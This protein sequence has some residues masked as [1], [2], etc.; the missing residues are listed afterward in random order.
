M[1]KKM[2]TLFR[3]AGNSKVDDEYEKTSTLS[4]NARRYLELVRLSLELEKQKEKMYLALNEQEK[5]E[6]QNVLS[7]ITEPTIP[8]YLTVR[9]VALLLD[10]TPQMVRRYC[11]EGKIDAYQRLEGSG[12]WIIPTAQF[13]HHPNWSAFLRKRQKVKNQ[14]INI[15]EKMLEYLEEEE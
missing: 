4:E 14:S 10:V 2:T 13:L 11:A 8:E 15:A 5:E 12:K 1:N 3:T 9:D 7:Q 6:V